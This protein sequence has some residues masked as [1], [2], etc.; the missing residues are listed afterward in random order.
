MVKRR[1]RKRDVARVA[2]G[3]AQ[4]RPPAR[5]A[6]APSSNR[7]RGWRVAFLVLCTIGVCLSA[8]LLRLHVNVHTNPDYRSYCAMS[9]RVNCDTV[10]AS[11]AS[12]FLELPLALW[13]LV[14]YTAMGVLAAWG[15][16]SRRHPRSWPFGLLFWIGSACAVIAVALFL[17]SHFVVE[18]VCIVCAGTYLVN[19]GLALTGWMALR[20]TR[21]PASQALGAEIRTIRAR[22]AAFGVFAGGFAVVLLLLWLFVPHYWSFEAT[23]GPAGL[24]VGK[25]PDGHPWIGSRDP[26]LVIEEYSDYQCP[27]CRKGHDEIRKLLLEHPTDVRLVHR[28]YPLDHHCNSM[29]N[30]P[31]HVNA[32]EYASMSYCALRQGRF[33]EANDYL[34]T[35]GRRRDPVKPR[36]LAGAVDLELDELDACLNGDAPGRAIE[37]D[38][39][40]GRSLQ[41]RGTP[42]FVVDGRIYPGRLPPEVINTKLG[43]SADDTSGT[44]ASRDTSQ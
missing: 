40:A 7:V 31:F 34:Y 18:S 21:T 42:T 9:E 44:D 37:E 6:E 19:V 24:P 33:W 39:A 10:A 22:P 25:T 1:R 32:C 8:D 23:S 13:G 15:L 17:I 35:Q 29:V 43:L 27:H 11:D 36:E 14:G 12:V 3:A 2:G 16:G 4:Q 28:H 30:R 26:V 38:L 5:P 41:I 20:Q